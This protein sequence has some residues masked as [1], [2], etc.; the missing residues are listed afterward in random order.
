MQGFEEAAVMLSTDG[1]GYQI[2]QRIEHKPE[3]AAADGSIEAQALAAVGIK[4]EKR[5]AASSATRHGGGGL[6]DPYGGS[7]GGGGG[8]GADPFEDLGM[9]AAAAAAGVSKKPLSLRDQ[10]A[11]NKAA[12]EEAWK[13]KHN[14]FSQCTQRSCT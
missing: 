6:G 13:E 3:T 11:A 10:L 1:L 9:A 5:A 8:G 2:E 14:P 4:G 12:Q 7:G